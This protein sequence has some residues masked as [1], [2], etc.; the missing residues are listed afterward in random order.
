MLGYVKICN[1]SQFNAT[2]IL[3]L[4]IFIYF[5]IYPD[6]NVSLSQPKMVLVGL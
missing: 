6:A 5:K 4:E 1:P 3:N 2:I